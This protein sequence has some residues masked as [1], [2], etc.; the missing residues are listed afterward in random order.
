MTNEE[1]RKKFL[2]DL[3]M[4]RFERIITDQIIFYGPY[5]E[6]FQLAM[7]LIDL[8][9]EN[10]EYEDKLKRNNFILLDRTEIRIF[11]ETKSFHTYWIPSSIG[12]S[13]PINQQ[14]P[15]YV[16]KY[17]ITDSRVLIT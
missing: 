13:N 15:D 11:T 9:F 1:I 7:V 17:K 6:T 2:F 5:L 3:T 10:A 16:K 12:N 14:I 8:G 4:G